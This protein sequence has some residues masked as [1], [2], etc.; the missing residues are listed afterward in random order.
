[1]DMRVSRLLLISPEAVGAA[2]IEPDVIHAI[3]PRIGERFCA[4]RLSRASDVYV[5][6]L[7]DSAVAV[8]RECLTCAAEIPPLHKHALM[9]ALA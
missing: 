1:M 6:R 7:G 2:L 4:G 9:D 8:W 3:D 5:F